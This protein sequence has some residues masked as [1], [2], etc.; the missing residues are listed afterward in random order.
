MYECIYIYIYK[1]VC[2]YIHVCIYIY[3][4]VVTPP[5]AQRAAGCQVHQLM[6]GTN[7]GCGLPTLFN[8]TD[9]NSQA[10]Q[11]FKATRRVL[12]E[13]LKVNTT[14][15]LTLPLKCKV[16]DKHNSSTRK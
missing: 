4:Y 15:W 5:C 11:H 10:E 8:F 13:L 7:V 1:Y 2:I 3:I 9:A 14:N 6:P 16:F 12:G